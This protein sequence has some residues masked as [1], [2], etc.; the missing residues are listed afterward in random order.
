MKLNTRYAY[1]I[2]FTCSCVDYVGDLI[3]RV[4]KLDLEWLYE[5]SKRTVEKC[6][7]EI[8]KIVVGYPGI[9]KYID[10]CPDEVIIEQLLTILHHVVKAVTDFITSYGNTIAKYA[11]EYEYTDDVKSLNNLI[12]SRKFKSLYVLAEELKNKEDVKPKTL[13][14]AYYYTSS[15]ELQD[16][17]DAVKAYRDSLKKQK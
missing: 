9:Y 7:E 1:I 8:E 12:H 16:Y 17:L 11:I 13:G 15:T 2:L 4:K 6:K 5:D 3:E 10:N 14:E